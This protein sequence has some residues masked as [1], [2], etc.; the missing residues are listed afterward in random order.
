M[1]RNVSVPYSCLDCDSSCRNPQ[2]LFCINQYY[3]TIVSALHCAALGSLYRVPCKCLKPFWDEKFYRLKNDSIFW[4][5]LWAS[6]GRLS[7][8]V[9]RIKCACKHKNKSAINDAY[10][11][12]ENKHND[13]LFNH[14]VIQEC[15]IQKNVN[16]QVCFNDCNN[17]VDI[18]SFA[19]HSSSVHY[20]SAS[21]F[22]A[23]DA[24]LNL[25]AE[26]NTKVNV[27]SNDAA[28]SFSVSIIDDCISNLK[29]GKACGPHDLA[30]EHL[31][32][33]HPSLIVRLKFLFGAVSKHGFLPEGFGSGTER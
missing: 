16:K 25:H 18:A 21:G 31:L 22:N 28:S 33:A 2:H 1:P 15:Q 8:T 6:S 13:E 32:R 20:N 27:S 29:L 24:F 10:V 9:R 4:H 19:Q 12:F 11:V 7:G 30:A 17:D 23:V 26:C 14:F 3:D 5:N